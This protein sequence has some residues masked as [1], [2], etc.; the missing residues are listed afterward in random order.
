MRWSAHADALANIYG[1]VFGRLDDYDKS[2]GKVTSNNSG[3]DPNEDISYWAWKDTGETTRY[4]FFQLQN[5]NQWIGYTKFGF[6]TETIL[7][8]I[9]I[10]KTHR[11]S[12]GKSVR[13]CY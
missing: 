2:M 13:F 5:G 10:A 1:C 6:L 7:N 4:R 11:F 8:R 9:K 12:C 3:K